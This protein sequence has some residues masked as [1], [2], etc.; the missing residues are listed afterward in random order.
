MY[1]FEDNTRLPAEEQIVQL[2]VYQDG[3]IKHTPK[4]FGDQIDIDLKAL[5]G[6]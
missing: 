4:G 2:E 3:S 1:Y 6:F 5:I